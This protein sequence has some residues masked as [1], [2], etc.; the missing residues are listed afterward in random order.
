MPRGVNPRDYRPAAPRNTTQ[1]LLKDA[2]RRQ[3]AGHDTPSSGDEHTDAGGL[4]DDEFE[5]LGSGSMAAAFG[6]RLSGAPTPARSPE[7]NELAATVKQQKVTIGKLEEEVSALRKQLAA[8]ANA[9][10]TAAAVPSTASGTRPPGV[11]YP[12]PG[13]SMVRL[14]TT[15]VAAVRPNQAA[16]DSRSGAG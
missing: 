9:S 15:P 6:A 5:D 11:A 13:V 14:G 3:R 4:G 10:A 2:S 16:I 8:I 1:E 12:P 7:E